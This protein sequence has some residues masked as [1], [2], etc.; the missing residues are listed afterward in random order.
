MLL[1]QSMCRTAAK[2]S[3]LGQ[4]SALSLMAFLN[5][6]SPFARKEA[7]FVG[8]GEEPHGLS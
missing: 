1:A 5:D 8:P 6:Y 7:I 2:N 4:P 3:G